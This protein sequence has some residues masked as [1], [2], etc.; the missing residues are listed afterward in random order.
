MVSRRTGERRV[1]FDA[2]LD[3][4]VVL[5][6]RASVIRYIPPPLAPRVRRA[7]RDFAVEISVYFSPPSRF[8]AWQKK[9]NHHLLVP[10][11]FLCSFG[12]QALGLG[13]RLRGFGT[14][15]E[16]ASARRTSKLP[17]QLP[18][19]P[20]WRQAK[21]AFVSN[22]WV[23]ARAGSGAGVGGEGQRVA[24]AWAPDA[25]RRPPPRLPSSPET[26]DG[27]RDEA[28]EGEVALEPPDDERD[29]VRRE[30]DRLERG[31][32]VRVRPNGGRG[33]AASPLPATHRLFVF[34]ILDGF[35]VLVPARAPGH[36]R[37]RDVRRVG[38]V[39]AERR[40]PE[41][42][43]RGGRRGGSLRERSAARGRCAGASARAGGE[44]PARRAEKTP[45]TRGGEPP[46]SREVP[47]HDGCDHERRDSCRRVV[48]LYFRIRI[49]AGLAS[50]AVIP[51]GG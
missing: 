38:G 3:A 39:R 16:S 45:D 15:A 41:R 5:S 28:H 43:E 23:G 46:I 47:T 25:A 2:S 42:G 50:L 29:D 13:A 37:P 44:K 18:M 22:T 19:S 35:H 11:W 7:R 24:S 6:V 36:V 48:H 26:Q 10:T 49:R 30:R 31:V 33:H 14:N 32:E 12:F 4:R 27:V 51:S 20:P 8:F 1:F 21:D 9:S 40:H 17:S 34:A